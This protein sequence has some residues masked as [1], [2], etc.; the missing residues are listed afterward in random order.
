MTTTKTQSAAIDATTGAPATDTTKA[1][2]IIT[3]DDGKTKT[4]RIDNTTDDK[5]SDDVRA[6]LA[7]NIISNRRRL[8][9][10]RAQLAKKI[11]ITE[12]AV[13]QYERATRAPSII[14]LCKLSN[15][16]GITVD[17]LIG[18]DNTEFDSVME[19][20]FEKACEVVT[21]LG[22]SL[23]EDDDGQIT[24]TEKSRYFATLRLHNN[25]AVAEQKPGTRINKIVEFA[26][27][28]AFIYFVEEVQ[29]FLMCQQNVR[30]AFLYA[31]WYFSGDVEIRF[32]ADI[33]VID[34]KSGEEIA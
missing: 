32:Y 6:I 22:F 15:V 5:E 23:I 28:E 13:G 18:H 33:K 17:K 25:K 12:A 7:G 27:R 11:G 21:N 2:V 8:K 20:R 3:T 19:Y 16:F 9:M 10:S 24:I 31:K 1:T 14:F 29:N 30:T 26:N 34:L 4:Y